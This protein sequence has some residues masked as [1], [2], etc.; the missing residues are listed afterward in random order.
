MQNLY[1][2]MHRLR[3]E[4][5]SGHNTWKQNVSLT[6]LEKKDLNLREMILSFTHIHCTWPEKTL[7]LRHWMGCS[8]WI[9]RRFSAITWMVITPD[10]STEVAGRYF[11]DVYVMYIPTQLGSADCSF[12]HSS[13]KSKENTVCV[14]CSNCPLTHLSCWNK[15]V[16]SK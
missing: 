3:E 16:F 15:F 11:R 2:K 10:D 14:L 5:G 6:H 8:L 9:K 1:N 4:M 7:H 12:L 13:K